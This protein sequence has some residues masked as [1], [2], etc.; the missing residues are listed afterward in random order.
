VHHVVT[1]G[2][3]HNGTWLARFAHGQNGRQMRQDSEWLQQLNRL[4][5]LVGASPADESAAIK[6]PVRFTCWYSNCDNIVFPASTATLQGA[7]NRLV[8]G[9]GHLELAFWPEV[10]EK[11]FELVTSSPNL[12]V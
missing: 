10:M 3:P 11:T 9:A 12:D 7:D 8:Q 1:I 2:T 4:K 6:T 5:T